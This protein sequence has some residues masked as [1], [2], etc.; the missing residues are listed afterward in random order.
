MGADTGTLVVERVANGWRDR[1]REYQIQID[2]QPRF[3][4]RRGGRQALELTPGPHQVRAAIDWTGSPD[5]DVL[6][7]ADSVTTC[8]VEPAGS[9]FSAFWR[10]WGRS[11][12]LKLSTAT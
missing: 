1:F 5:L 9:L 2:G 12:Y 8:R 10:I 7:V 11:H 6:I 4:I 3:S